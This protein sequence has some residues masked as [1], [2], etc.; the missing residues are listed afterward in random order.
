MTTTFKTIVTEIQF[1]YKNDITNIITQ[2][3]PENLS[4]EKARAWANKYL[5]DHA[6]ELGYTIDAKSRG[7]ASIAKI[8]L[9]ERTYQVEYNP[10]DFISENPV[11]RKK[12]KVHDE[13]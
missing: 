6:A 4:T 9:Y 13:A 10:D 8:S 7:N 3:V 2:K 11:E 1:A 12:R 5:I